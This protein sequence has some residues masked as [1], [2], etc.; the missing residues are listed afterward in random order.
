MIEEVVPPVLQEYVVPPDAVIVAM[1]PEQI[2]EGVTVGL[3]PGDMA[4]VVTAVSLHPLAFVT[5][6]E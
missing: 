6:T 2:I 1:S 4:T 5:I 3:I